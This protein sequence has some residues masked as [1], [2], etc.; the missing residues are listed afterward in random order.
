MR[1]L[2]I[3]VQ[4]FWTLFYVQI[5]KTFTK[6]FYGCNLLEHLLKHILFLENKVLK[7]FGVCF[8]TFWKLCEHVLKTCWN[9]VCK[10]WNHILKTYWKLYKLLENLL[11]IQILLKAFWNLFYFFLTHVWT[12]PSSR[13]TVT[14]SALFFDSEWNGR[15][16]EEQKKRGK[17]NHSRPF[18]SSPLSSV[19][20]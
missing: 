4:R 5:Y 3:N 16:A 1:M 15:R 12:D 17:T 6:V 8:A 19:L 18:I 9:S 7:T 14:L 13:I 2:L 20:A 11:N 10:R